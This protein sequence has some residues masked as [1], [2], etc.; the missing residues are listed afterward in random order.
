MRGVRALG[1]RTVTRALRMV[2]LNMLVLDHEDTGMTTV[3]KAAVDEVPASLPRRLGWA[4]VARRHR[5]EPYPKRPG[6]VITTA[7]PS[8]SPPTGA[9]SHRGL[10]PCVCSD[11]VSSRTRSCAWSCGRDLGTGAPTPPAPQLRRL[12][13]RGVQYLLSRMQGGISWIYPVMRKTR[14]DS[15]HRRVV[16]RSRQPTESKLYTHPE[17]ATGFHFPFPLTSCIAGLF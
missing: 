11:V 5:L 6:P 9:I 1:K 7:S 3:T 10:P 15:R 13:E 8:S 17:Q 4:L 14:P 2:Y 12:R 16:G